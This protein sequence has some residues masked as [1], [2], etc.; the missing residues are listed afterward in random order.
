MKFNEK[1]L[2]LTSAVKAAS[3]I[4]VCTIAPID[5]KKWNKHR[6]YKKK[7]IHLKQ[8]GNYKEIQNTFEE[9]IIQINKFILEM[10]ITNHMIT[11][12]IADTV[13][14]EKKGSQNKKLY[15]KLLDGLHTGEDLCTKW[16]ELIARRIDANF[17]V[18]MSAATALLPQTCQNK[19]DS[20]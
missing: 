6:L 13:F 7:T 4:C 5:I 3:H 17:S 1:I 15:S 2:D 12:F 14:T 11:P 18:S 8:Q 19:K 10:N 9:A 16:G 20:P